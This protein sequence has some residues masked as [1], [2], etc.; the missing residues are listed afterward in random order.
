MDANDLKQSIED[1]WEKRDAISPSTAGGAR[2]SVEVALDG[3]GSGRY[4]VAE[5]A[6]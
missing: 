5:R 3:L 6:D 1:A 4:R 2:Q